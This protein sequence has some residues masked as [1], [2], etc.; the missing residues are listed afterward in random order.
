M[1]HAAKATQ[2]VRRQQKRLGTIFRE[3][4]EL[5]LVKKTEEGKHFKMQIKIYRKVKICLQPWKV[6]SKGGLKQNV[7]NHLYRYSVFT[8]P[9]ASYG[10]RYI[11]CAPYYDLCVLLAQYGCSLM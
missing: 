1:K 5:R 6:L 2:L 10:I 11:G 9:V 7:C 8:F 4:K 3:K